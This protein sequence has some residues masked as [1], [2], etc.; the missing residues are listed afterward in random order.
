MEVS[1]VDC[2]RK[3]GD[4][5]VGVV[6]TITAKS[7]IGYKHVL[8]GALAAI[9][10]VI[11]VSGVGGFTCIA[12]LIASGT[13]VQATSFDCAK[14]HR[15]YEALICAN[16]ELSKA[17]DALA[18]A[19]RRA[20]GAL[21]SIGPQK[22]AKR[23]QQRLEKEQKE[24]LKT[25]QSKCPDVDCLRR[26]YQ[27]RLATLQSYVPGETTAEQLQAPPPSASSSQVP[28]AAITA[29]EVNPQPPSNP[30]QP[31]PQT[32]PLVRPEA[33]RQEPLATGGSQT[34][35]VSSVENVQQ[36][37]VRR[38]GPD[39]FLGLPIEAGFAIGMIVLFTLII[40]AYC[41]PAIIA[42]SRRHHNRWVILA[43]N[44]AFGATLIGWVIALVWAL[45]KV[46]A[47]VKGGWKYD[48]QPN[49]P[50]L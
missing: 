24:W 37:V 26:E 3:R 22:E 17:D 1:K 20:H 40:A 46:D 2:I 6:A 42:F 16:Q 48:P 31:E 11:G 44:L 34:P 23:A 50:I 39:G 7:T 45:N 8:L 9:L 47:P 5:A 12:I 10:T 28:E 41:L 4:V 32:T 38:S 35:S 18:D 25:R 36:P 43:I 30:Q 15:G 33:A 21:A 19:Y 29:T 13:E 14:A 49:D 27:L